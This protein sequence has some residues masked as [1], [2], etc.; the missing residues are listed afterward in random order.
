MAKIIPI[1]KR[2]GQLFQDSPENLIDLLDSLP[3]CV[4]YFDKEQR[5]QFNNKT[6]E[7]WFGISQRELQGKYI[8][9]AIGKKVY[10]SVRGHIEKALTGENVTYDAELMKKDGT[11]RFVQVNLYHTLMIRVM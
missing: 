2:S 9:E 4:S 7:E 10:E 1:H 11:T 8:W 3:A 6:Y 5:F